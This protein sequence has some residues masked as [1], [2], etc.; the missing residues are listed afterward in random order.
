MKKRLIC[1]LL[2]LLSVTASAFGQLPRTRKLDQT[3]NLYDIRRAL[4]KAAFTRLVTVDSSG[5][6]DYATITDALAYVTTQTRGVTAQWLVLVYPGVAGTNSNYTE[7]CLSVPSYTQV[8]GMIGATHDGVQGRI[9]IDL[10]CTATTAAVTMGASSSL[11]DLAFAFRGLNV[12]ATAAIEIPS[13]VTANLTRIFINHTPTSGGTAL[14]PVLVGGTITS[15]DLRL[16]ASA[17]AGAVPLIKF[18]GTGGGTLYAGNVNGSSGCTA[19]FGI[20]GTGTVRLFG[21]RDGGSCTVDIDSGSAGSTVEVSGGG[22]K[23]TTGPSASGTGTLRDL[24][25][26]VGGST[27]PTTCFPGGQYIDNVTPRACWCTALNIWQCVGI[28]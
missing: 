13:G 6:G 25:S 18:T 11:L 28:S 27:L 10:T 17:N 9:L 3:G 16:F 23:A 12:S 19:A 4:A 20:T 22:W 2:L 24:L 26:P 14:P 8:R 1:L 21:M 15:T 7:S 5:M